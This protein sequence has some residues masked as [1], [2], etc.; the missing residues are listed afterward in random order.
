MGPGKEIPTIPNSVTLQDTDDEQI[1][2]IIES[3]NNEGSLQNIRTLADIRLQEVKSAKAKLNKRDI[4]TK[5]LDKYLLIHSRMYSRM[6]GSWPNP[7][8]FSIV[9]I[10]GDIILPQIDSFTA[11]AKVIHFKYKS[12]SNSFRYATVDNMFSQAQITGFETETYYVSIKEIS[13][14]LTKEEAAK[15]I[16]EQKDR[17][18]NNNLFWEL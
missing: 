6:G 15:F 1:K 5:Y 16:K 10:I 11:H 17:V 9:H 7:D 3:M 8:D 4:E 12:E 13:K 2:K 18:D 14:I